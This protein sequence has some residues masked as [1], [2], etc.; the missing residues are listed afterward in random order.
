LKAALNCSK[1][2]Y[3]QVDFDSRRS[4]QPAN[5]RFPI[6]ELRA[7]RSIFALWLSFPLYERFYRF[8]AWLFR[9]SFAFF[10]IW[11]S[12][13]DILLCLNIF[14][15]IHSPQAWRLASGL[16]MIMRDYRLAII[17]PESGKW[18][19]HFLR[20]CVAGVEEVWSLDQVQCWRLLQFF[21]RWVFVWADSGALFLTRHCGE[22]SD[23]FGFLAWLL[24]L[25]PMLYYLFSPKAR[26]GWWKGG[27]FFSKL[28]LELLCVGLSQ[29]HCIGRL[30]FFNFLRFWF[31]G[32][33]LISQYFEKEG[34]RKWEVR[35]HAEVRLWWADFALEN[36]TRVIPNWLQR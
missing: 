10:T 16:L 9:V 30:H 1:T 19:Y 6:L 26:S 7:L 15:H 20:L 31:P 24:F 13:P 34:F 22:R 25:L 33:C 3:L 29:N 2:D 14:H 32:D 36:R 23:T 35:C 21:V 12:F 5:R 28:S 18:P 4:I 27:P 8:A 17:L 11:F